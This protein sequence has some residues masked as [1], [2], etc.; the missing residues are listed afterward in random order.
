MNGQR[1]IKIWVIIIIRFNH[2]AKHNNRLIILQI[3]R[4]SGGLSGL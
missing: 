1:D 3:D 4:V 2:R